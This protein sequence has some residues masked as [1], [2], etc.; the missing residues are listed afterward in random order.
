MDDSGNMRG[1]LAPASDSDDSYVVPTSASDADD[2][3]NNDD[4]NQDA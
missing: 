1:L 4:G 2:A 3:D